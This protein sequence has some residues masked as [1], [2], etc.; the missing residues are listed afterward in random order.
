M[1]N[2]LYDSMKSSPSKPQANLAQT[3]QQLKSNPT[4]FLQRMGFNIPS[5]VDLRNPQSII[6]S[7]M[8]SGQVNNAKYYQAM[9]NMRH[10]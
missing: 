2:P 6:N 4:E 3:V 1:S 9:Q 7:L 10:R 5:G 8:Q